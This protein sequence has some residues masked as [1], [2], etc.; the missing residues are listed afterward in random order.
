MKKPAPR[1]CRS[2]AGPSEPFHRAAII[3][4]CSAKWI[5]SELCAACETKEAQ[6]QEAER[7]DRAL[8]EK[9]RLAG[10]DAPRLQGARL[11]RFKKDTPARVRV[12]N[13]ARPLVARLHGM[14]R[15]SNLVL[16][17]NSGTGKTFLAAALARE[18]MGLGQRVR[19][20]CWPELC[21]ALRDADKKGL[22][23]ALIASLLQHD[24]LVLDDVGAEKATEFITEN[25]YLIVN[26]WEL[27]QQP[28][29]VVTTNLSLQRLGEIYADRIVSR[30]V[31]MS[32]H[33]DYDGCSDGRLERR[34]P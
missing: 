8:V 18:A 1:P 17:G 11:D 20:W 27:E 2:C 4:V 24:V 6:S 23:A 21:L 14:G 9:L 26:R 34:T 3:G 13:A 32:I 33:I 16:S 30:L 31:G 28:G 29:L 15:L 19:F 12:A 10:M 7:H 5:E 22:K 25:F